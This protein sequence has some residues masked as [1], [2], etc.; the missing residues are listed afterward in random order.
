L[1]E[2]VDTRFLVEHFYS[3]QTE[4]KRRTSKKLK[5]LIE[6]REGLLPTIVICETVQVTCEKR[7]KEEAEARYLSLVRSGLQIQDVNQ[8]VAK[9]AGLL[10][11][12]Y[13]NIPIGDCII[14]AIATINK[15]KVLSDDQHFDTIEEIKRTWIETS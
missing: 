6:N 13:R 9:E 3:N 10:K 7:G 12:R 2:V 4:I 1:K 5:E 14:A 8:E 15:A 11:C